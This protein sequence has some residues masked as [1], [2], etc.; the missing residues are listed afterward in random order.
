MAYTDYTPEE[1]VRRG[2]EL[3]ERQIRSKVEPGNI[4]KYVVIDI[5]SGDYEVGE[6]YGALSDCLHQRHPNA[7]LCALRIGYRALGKMGGSW[8][9]LRG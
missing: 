9:A 2:R 8:S 6:D 4:G 1:A 7:A 3:Y 5:E